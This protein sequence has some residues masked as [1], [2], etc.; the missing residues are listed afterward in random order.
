[1]HRLLI[2][3]L[4]L[5]MVFAGCE[6]SDGDGAYFFE[7]EY[8][9]DDEYEEDLLE[10]QKIQ[11]VIPPPP[12]DVIPEDLE[13]RGFQDAQ[14]KQF[15]PESVKDL[16]DVVTTNDKLDTNKLVANII[17]NLKYISKQSLGLAFTC[18]YFGYFT[19]NLLIPMKEGEEFTS[20]YLPRK[21]GK[22]KYHFILM[23][24][25]GNI[26]CKNYAVECK[27]NTMGYNEIFVFWPE[28]D[29][30]RTQCGMIFAISDEY[31][32]DMKTRLNINYRIGEEDANYSSFGNVEYLLEKTIPGA[33]L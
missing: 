17:N 20:I 22:K 27:Q 26:G 33:G 5:S 24:Y 30:Q 29:K 25:K 4:A 32:K 7:D 1:M 31:L 11:E 18:E 8:Y 15:K 28:N 12:V 3:F 19:S 14:D 6:E 9:E 21:F 10:E 16:I 13:E 23:N 2:L